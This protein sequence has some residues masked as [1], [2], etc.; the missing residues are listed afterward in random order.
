MCGKKSFNIIKDQK[1]K[2]VS[3]YASLTRQ[4]PTNQTL[5]GNIVSISSCGA[6]P[7]VR[8][9]VTRGLIYSVVG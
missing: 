1:Q 6:Y 4:T 9:V 7:P 8:S 5:P 3:G 2:E